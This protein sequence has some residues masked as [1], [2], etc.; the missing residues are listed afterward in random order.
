[1]S[2]YLMILI[3]AVGVVLVVKGGDVFV[4]AA[5][6]IATEL[7]IPKF[8]IG[9]T[10]VSLATT[11]PELMVSSFA[12]AGGQSDMAVGNAV[13]SVIGN[14]GLIMAIAMIFMDYVC[15]RKDYFVQSLILL[16]SVCLL[17]ITGRDGSVSLAANI[18]F[19]ILFF[20]YMYV[21]VKNAKNAMKEGKA[22]EDE[23]IEQKALGKEFLLFALGAVMI[24]FGSRFMVNSGTGIAEYFKVPERVIAVTIVAIGTSLPE[25]VT[26]I[27]AIAKKEPSL[28]IGNIIGANILNV[29][30]IM[31][32]ASFISAGGL[33]ISEGAMTL[34]LPWMVGI[35]ILAI[36]PIMIKERSYKLQGYLML[37]AY[38]V[39]LAM[40]I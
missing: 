6:K 12:A 5:S 36:V 20:V 3:F 8:L 10:I 27:T 29:T 30:M 28:S 34:D 4:D 7:H 39:Y 31:P 32:V 40:V 22:N 1:M 37:A 14:Q 17:F 25:L 26:T 13:G 11:L 15:K 16:I 9:A 21:N 19:V 38:A 23:N 18:V 35:T 33:K 2:I 24:V